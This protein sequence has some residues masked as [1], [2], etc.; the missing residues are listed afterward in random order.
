M[1]QWV[2]EV[3]GKHDNLSMLLLNSLWKETTDSR[4]LLTELHL[5]LLHVHTHMSILHTY[6]HDNDT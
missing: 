5:L 1:A 3:A 2:K 4:K 6:T